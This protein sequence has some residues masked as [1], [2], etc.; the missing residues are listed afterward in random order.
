M[1]ASNY[2][3]DATAFIQI[4]NGSH[5]SHDGTTIKIGGVASQTPCLPAGEM[6]FGVTGE[7]DE[8][9]H[10]MAGTVIENEATSWTLR[11]SMRL[12][13]RWVS[14]DSTRMENAVEW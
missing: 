6:N 4:N 1:I 9:G 8:S 10:Q 7:A 5:A 13:R 3:G 14:G 2:R 12:T 11:W